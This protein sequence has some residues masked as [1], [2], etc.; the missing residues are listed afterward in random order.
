TPKLADGPYPHDAEALSANNVWAVGEYA[1]NPL[2]RQM[3]LLH[4]NGQAW[5]TSPNPMPGQDTRLQALTSIGDT[6]WA[7]G[8]QGRDGE[9]KPL[10]L[11]YTPSSCSNK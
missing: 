3:L 9:S 10:F 7:V 1:D 2:D 6:I 5:N 8:S 11:R 4:W